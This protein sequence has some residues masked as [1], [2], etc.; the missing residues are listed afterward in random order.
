MSEL[1]ADSHY[2]PRAPAGG[3]EYYVITEGQTS[4]YGDIV[5][6]DSVQLIPGLVTN[7][8]LKNRSNFLDVNTYTNK[9]NQQMRMMF[10]LD[11]NVY[12]L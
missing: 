1:C 3:G 2:C 8:I 12:N 5:T 4:R 9:Y 10:T 6:T 11:T 7:D